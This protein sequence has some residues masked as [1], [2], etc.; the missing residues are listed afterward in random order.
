MPVGALDQ[1][2]EA[3]AASSRDLTWLERHCRKIKRWR[4]GADGG[5]VR[6][7]IDP[8]IGGSALIPGSALV[9]DDLQSAVVI[10]LLQHFR[11]ERR[12][13]LRLMQANGI[14]AAPEY[15]CA[16]HFDPQS[17]VTLQVSR[18]KY[19]A[20]QEE[21]WPPERRR[22][23]GWTQPGATNSRASSPHASSHR[24]T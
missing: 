6:D 16:V 1:A 10:E 13:T 2:V 14:L 15:Q 5:H 12:G 3:I 4:R 22:L 20:L 18:E 11:P 17:I 24:R 9:F 21:T 23:V 8:P 7:F 19:W